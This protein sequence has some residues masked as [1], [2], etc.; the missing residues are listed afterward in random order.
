[1][2]GPIFLNDVVA[3]GA[4]ARLEV[5]FDDGTSLTLGE[6]AEMRIDS[7]VYAPSMGAARMRAA[8]TGAFRF[9]S[10]GI[11]QTAAADV[12]VTTPVATIGIRGTDFFGGPIDSQALG[13]L[14]LEGAVIVTNPAGEAILDAPGEGTNI[15]APGAPPGPV[16]QWPEDKVNRALASVAF[17]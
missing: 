5:T 8:V 17:Q 4:A 10:G 13:V 16:T 2:G 3:T 14:L 7:F 9:I 11:G 1:M 12:A 15:A 6:S